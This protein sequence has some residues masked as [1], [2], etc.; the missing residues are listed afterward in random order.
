MAPRMHRDEISSDA[1]LVR[2]LLTAQQPQWADRPIT[3]VAS[4][5]TDNAL[6]R[7]GD[8]L[9]ARL[10]LRPSSTAT[11]ERE[12]T[13][14]PVLAPHLPLA[15]PVPLAKGA[16]TDDYPWPWSVLP[17]LPGDD[18]TTA[19]IDAHR[20][21]RELARFL[22][23]LRAVDAAG[24]PPPGRDNYGRGAPLATRDA[25]TRQAIRASQDVIDAGAAMAAWEAALR[26]PPWEHPSVWIHGDV[27]AGNLLFEGGSP[28]AVIDWGALGVGDPACDVMVAW[29][30][31]GVETR[32]VFRAELG[33]DDATWER[34]R[35][36][37]LSSAAMALSYYQGT[38]PFIVDQALRKLQAV[39][40][41]SDGP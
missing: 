41:R 21:A 19:P 3:P 22:R 37:A 26:V 31:F 35:G 18:G 10:P 13:W 38:N 24:G 11:I 9:V 23:A 7:L 25:S 20:T 30:L 12:R 15:V 6:Y 36:W 4:T 29:E 40:D 14:L 5:G 34:S 33:V 16:P 2:A 27:A 39:L 32:G 28:S 8:D 1:D 17:W